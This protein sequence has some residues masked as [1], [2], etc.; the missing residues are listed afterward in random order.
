LVIG[1]L[2]NNAFGRLS[3]LT[4]PAAAQ[5]VG[6]IMFLPRYLGF[7]YAPP[8]QWTRRLR[9]LFFV[10]VLVISW[11]VRSERRHPCLLS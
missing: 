9:P 11:I 2:A 10:F 6:S 5:S 3:K 4:F 8:Q 1:Y 7:R